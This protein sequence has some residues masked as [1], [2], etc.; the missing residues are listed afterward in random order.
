MKLR[1][2]PP[3]TG[4][5]W[6]RQG[7]RTFIRQPLALTGLFFMF[8]TS[9]LFMALVPFAGLAAVLVLTPAGTLGLLVGTQ[10]AEEG[11]FPW[12]SCLVQG[13]RAGREKRRQLLVLGFINAAI[14][15]VIVAAVFALASQEPIEGT[16]PPLAVTP[17]SLAAA[18]LQ[19][20]LT[21]L[22]TLAPALVFWHDVPA[23]KAIFFSAVAMWRNLGAYCVFALAWVAIL[24]GLLFAARLLVQLS[25]PGLGL[26]LLGPLLMVLFAMATTSLFHMYRD[27]FEPDPPEALPPTDGESP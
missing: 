5:T 2:V 4:L 27:S 15:G 1:V 9:L 13:F 24:A 11:R 17:A 16:A 23:A 7:V 3:R 22:F 20:P 14:V 8:W 18:V 21:L 19:L 10:Q 6:V 26:N 12:P 25:G